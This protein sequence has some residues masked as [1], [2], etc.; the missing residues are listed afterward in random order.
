M[1]IYDPESLLFVDE[2]GS[3]RKSALRM[4]GYSPIGTRAYSR[5]LL[6][7]G[8]RFSAISMM[9]INGM[10][11][12]YV[13]PNSV[14]AEIFED[15][16]DKSLLRHVMPFNGRNPNSV[17]ILDNASIHHTDG[18]VQALQSIGVLVH[19]LPPYSPDLNPIDEAF[20]KVKADLK[21]NDCAIQA[22]T[23][24]ALEDFILSAFCTITK[25]DC[26]QWYKH[27]GYQSQSR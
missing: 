3:D 16:I 17:V 19:F 26:Y 15:F 14:N 20:S 27:S 22:F 18:V 8:K 23:D 10:L 25:E 6:M 21:A 4:F 9:S 1:S 24:N 11:D 5:S 12:V 7:K 13:T 2:M